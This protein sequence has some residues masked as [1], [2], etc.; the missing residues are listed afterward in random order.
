MKPAGDVTYFDV[1]KP[2]RSIGSYESLCWVVGV[3]FV[4][5]SKRLFFGTVESYILIPRSR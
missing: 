5:E 2:A 1:F 4:L 3:S